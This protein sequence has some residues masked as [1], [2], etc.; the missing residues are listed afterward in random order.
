[1]S[2]A[3]TILI[4]AGLMVG[5]GTLDPQLERADLAKKRIML[6]LLT[7]LAGSLLPPFQ[8]GMVRVMPGSLFSIMAAGVLFLWGSAGKQ[9]VRSLLCAALTAA[10]LAAA[11]AFLPYGMDELN[12]AR[13]VFFGL[14]GGMVSGISAGTVKG[15]AA[16]A[17]WGTLLFDAADGAMAYFMDK[18]SV[19]LL[20]HTELADQAVIAMA[21]AVLI[22]VMVGYTIRQIEWITRKVG[23]T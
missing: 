6:I 11:N 23:R 2:M 5:F 19:L 8:W 22:A 10:L 18:G 16:T 7:L 13:Y 20:G 4:M 3:A 17:L 21:A 1:M 12:I 15:A 9:W 14:I